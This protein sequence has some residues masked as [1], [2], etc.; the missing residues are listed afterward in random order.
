MPTTSWVQTGKWCK[1][2]Q[3]FIPKNKWRFHSTTPCMTHIDNA[4]R[5]ELE[6]IAGGKA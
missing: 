6:R 1:T 5:N 4:Y 2:C 3:L